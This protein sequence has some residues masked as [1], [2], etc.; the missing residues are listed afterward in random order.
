VTREEASLRERLRAAERRAEAAESEVRYLKVLSAS[1]EMYRE[2]YRLAWQSARNRARS[3]QKNAE[4]LHRSAVH[5]ST[6]LTRLEHREA[7]DR[8]REMGD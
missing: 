2:R 8:L 3:M 1:H 4:V 5:M 7:L 6:E